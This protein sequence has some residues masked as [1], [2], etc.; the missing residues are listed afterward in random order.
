MRVYVDT[1][2]LKAHVTLAYEED[3]VPFRIQ[4]LLIPGNACVIGECESIVVE[5]Q[6]FYSLALL[7]QSHN[8]FVKAL[9]ILERIGT[10]LWS[11]KGEDG[12]D[13]TVQMLSG[14]LVCRKMCSL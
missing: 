4:E 7:Y 11:S 1:A 13:L 5:K 12:V 9:G 14:L 2:L 3:E 6:Q 8:D 10:G